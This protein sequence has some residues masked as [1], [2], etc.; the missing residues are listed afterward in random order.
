MVMP[1]AITYADKEGIC[2]ICGKHS[3]LTDDHVPP[4]GC[5][6]PRKLRLHHITQHLAPEDVPSKGRAFQS[7]VKFRTL[8]AN[9][10]NKVLGKD[11]DPSLIQFTK[12]MKQLLT[13]TK[14]KHSS[15][16]THP[17][18]VMRSV[19][20]HLC[21]V[22]VNRYEKGKITEPLRDYLLDNTMP[23]PS[24]I[25][26]YY[27]AYPK[28]DLLITK[29]FAYAD[30]SLGAAFMIWLLK[31]PPVGFLVSFDE[32]DN[33][34]FQINSLTPWGDCLYDYIANIPISQ[35]IPNELW[36]EA[37]KDHTLLVGGKEAHMA[38]LH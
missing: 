10:N 15:I 22:G 38:E 18:K 12:D 29:D 37:P 23:L 24:G 31:F 27:W 35:S 21:A 8:C 13:G 2:N 26:L 34:N 25:K 16:K 32:P 36:P 19:L 3:L 11:N 28:G 20:G 14:K 17:Q 6:P 33:N 9:C 4:K 1:L 5:F 7:G 30:I